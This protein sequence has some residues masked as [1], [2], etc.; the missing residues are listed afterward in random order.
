M[1]REYNEASEKVTSAQGSQEGG[2]TDENGNFFI[3]ERPVRS[4]PSAG[5][6]SRIGFPHELG[7]APVWPDGPASAR[8]S[9]LLSVRRRP[10]SDDW[11][12]ALHAR[13]IPLP[14]LLRQ[15]FKQALSAM[16]LSQPPVVAPWET[17]ALHVFLRGF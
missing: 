4:R 10:G 14:A 9:C 3:D 6:A 8:L 16:L 12:Q 15:A 17:L 2:K 7:A 11:E 1:T 5:A 13:S